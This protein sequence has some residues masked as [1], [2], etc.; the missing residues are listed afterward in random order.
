MKTAEGK[1]LKYTDGDNTVKLK[2]DIDATAIAGQTLTPYGIWG[3][4][5][6]DDTSTTDVDESKNLTWDIA[7]KD[8]PTSATD[9]ATIMTI[10]G[11]GNLA[12]DIATNA[13]WKDYSLDLILV[14]DETA[15]GTYKV[16][17]NATD[18][19]KLAPQELSVSAFEGWATY[20]H[21]YPVS[22]SLSNGATAHTISGLSDDGKSITISDEVPIS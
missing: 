11:T 13:P 6:K 4:C 12:A 2:G 1:A 8:E 18:K 20:C 7:L 22:Y 16:S 5:G 14:K 21:N 15:L 19:A 10:E 17:L 3:Y 9:L